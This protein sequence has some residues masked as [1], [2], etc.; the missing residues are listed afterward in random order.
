[1]QLSYEAGRHTIKIIRSTPVS[2]ALARIHKGECAGYQWTVT[3]DAVLL[4]GTFV[5]AAD[6][7]AAGVR[8]TDRVDRAGRPDTGYPGGSRRSTEAARR[9]AHATDGTSR[10]ASP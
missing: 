9:T 5:S 3:V 8:E 10:P 4:P 1:M 6:A 7:W 2:A